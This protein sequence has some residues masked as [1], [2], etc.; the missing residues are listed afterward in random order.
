VSQP[1]GIRNHNPGNIDHHPTNK[2]QGLADPPV[3]QGVARPRFARFTAPEWGIR[4]IARLLI[5]YQDKHDINTVRGILTRWA[6][7]IENDTGAYIASVSRAI[8]VAPDAPINVYE[9][10][11][12]RPLVEAI[13]KHENGVQPY[14]PAVIDEGLRRAGVVPPAAVAA[15]KTALSAEGVGAGTAGLGTAG[16]VITQTAQQMQLTSPEGG[17]S[18]IMQAVCALLMLVGVGLVVYGLIRQARERSA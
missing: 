16:T 7:A 18:M 2:W 10:A 6:P 12:M 1:R 8:G 11:T 9:Y 4:A 13:I 17:G 15:R 5:A 14:P 3:E